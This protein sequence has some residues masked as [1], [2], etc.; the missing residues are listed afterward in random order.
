VLAVKEH[1]DRNPKKL[2]VIVIRHGVRRD[3]ERQDD[4][5]PQ[6]MAEFKIS[7]SEVARPAIT[8]VT[9]M[10]PLEAHQ[11]FTHCNDLPRVQD[12]KRLP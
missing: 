12:L 5:R 4:E 10:I 8:E 6:P 11:T 1:K 7:C 3:D 2:S 9:A